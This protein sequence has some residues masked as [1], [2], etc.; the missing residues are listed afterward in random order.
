MISDPKDV[1]SL[2]GASPAAHPFV[3]AYKQ[4]KET[5]DK[6]DQLEKSYF[7][8]DKSKQIAQLLEEQMKKV[9]AVPLDLG[10]QHTT[11]RS[12]RQGPSCQLPLHSRPHAG[13]PHGL[14]QQDR[15]RTHIEGRTSDPHS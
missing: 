13:P 9:A 3:E 2:K 15:G 11:C 8:K 6:A 1:N 12:V 10:T 7:G 14:L 5:V 4:A